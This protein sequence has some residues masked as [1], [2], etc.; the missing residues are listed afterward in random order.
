MRN[1]I[2]TTSII[3]LFIIQGCANN[4]CEDQLCFTP[5]HSF[6]FEVVDKASGENLF[7]NGT[8]SPDQIEVLNAADNS[9]LQ[10]NFMDEDDINLISI[11]SIGW[12][13]E[14]VDVLLKISNT[15]ILDLHVDAER[16]SENCCSFTRYHEIRI[17][18][19][20]YEFNSQTGIYTV[21]IE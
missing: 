8:F 5:P 14:I 19:A 12:E 17:D 3:V 6:N 20:E 18:N 2:K 16:V 13:T 21:F 10:F 9:D 7:S 4:D 11:Y 15:N 1:L